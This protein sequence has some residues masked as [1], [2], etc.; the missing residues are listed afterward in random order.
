MHFSARPPSAGEA[1]PGLPAICMAGLETPHRSWVALGAGGGWRGPRSRLSPAG[2]AADG[3]AGKRSCLPAAAPLPRRPTA[4][5]EA[6]K[7]E[8]AGPRRTRRGGSEGQ[9]AAWAQPAGGATVPAAST[10]A[11]WLAA[12]EMS[13]AVG[14]VCRRQ[15]AKIRFCIQCA[16]PRLHRNT[17][18][19]RKDGGKALEGVSPG[20]ERL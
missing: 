7:K 18:R 16:I 19:R 8:K 20:A 5:G 17:Q 9:A 11:L 4:R 3:S 1:R 15:G 10:R 6:E 13:V 12:S 2:L 14:R